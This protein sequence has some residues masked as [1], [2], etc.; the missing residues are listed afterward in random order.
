MKDTYTYTAR[1]ADDPDEVAP[2][3]L[4]D[5]SLSV[6]LGGALLAR[7]ERVFQPEQAEGETQC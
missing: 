6:E 1:S 3:T 5:H 7:V 4:H 2:F